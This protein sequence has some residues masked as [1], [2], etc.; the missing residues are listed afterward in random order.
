[1]NVFS[2]HPPLNVMLCS[3]VRGLCGVVWRWGPGARAG[4]VRCFQDQGRLPPLRGPLAPEGP[5]P[6][7]RRR[8]PCCPV[9][10]GWQ[11]VREPG[12]VILLMSSLLVID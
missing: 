12:K 3:G 5:S 1:M 4:L 7:T 2:L 8:G 10:D 11:A 9:G 6:L